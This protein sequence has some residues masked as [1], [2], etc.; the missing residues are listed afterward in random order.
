MRLLCLNPLF[1]PGNAADH[2]VLYMLSSYSESVIREQKQKAITFVN[3]LSGFDNLVPYLSWLV[4]YIAT[5]P[6]R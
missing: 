1:P 6:V 5:Q 2:V 4:R 3:C